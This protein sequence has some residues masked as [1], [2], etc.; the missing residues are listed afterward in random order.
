MSN[1]ISSPVPYKSNRNY[2]KSMHNENSSTISP[3]DL[4]YKEVGK[5]EK[6]KK[7]KNIT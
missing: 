3:A 7:L 5:D 4:H 6:V 2:Q 1:S